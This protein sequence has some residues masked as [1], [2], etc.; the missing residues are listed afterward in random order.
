MIKPHFHTRDFCCIAVV[1]ILVVFS[2]FALILQPN[3]HAYADNNDDLILPEHN[4]NE[5]FVTIH[6]DGANLI[7]KTGAVTVAEALEKSAIQLAET[8]VVLHVVYIV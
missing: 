4:Q 3:S 8:L 6:D 1:A 2:S 7:V 5:Y